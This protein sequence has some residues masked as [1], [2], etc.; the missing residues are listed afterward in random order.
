MAIEPE[1]EGRV[2]VQYDFSNDE[3]E[4]EDLVETEAESRS[5]EA[6]RGRSRH[7]SEADPGL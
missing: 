6:A 2:E 3:M 4:P 7:V 1:L 5:P